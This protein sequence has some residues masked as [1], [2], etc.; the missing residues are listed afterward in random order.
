VIEPKGPSKTL[1]DVKLA[2]LTWVDWLNH[3]RLHRACGDIPPVEF[4]ANYMA[5]LSPK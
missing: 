4:E 3:R 2:T 1:S 5:E